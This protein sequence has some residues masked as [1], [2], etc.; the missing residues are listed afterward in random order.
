MRGDAEGD[1]YRIR[2]YS[3]LVSVRGGSLEL[4]RRRAE[5]PWGMT[6]AAQLFQPGSPG[7]SARPALLR[8]R[9]PRQQEDR[10]RNEVKGDIR[11]PVVVPL[12]ARA[13]GSELLG[14]F[15]RALKLPVKVFDP[16]ALTPGPK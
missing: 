3:P 5:V 12:G 2:R 11:D 8:R 6:Y 7:V 9:R 10:R 4:S 14:I 13:V 15:E 16:E 1:Y